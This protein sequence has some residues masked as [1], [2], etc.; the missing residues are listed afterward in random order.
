MKLGKK[1]I[2]SLAI[3]L[4]LVS[5]TVTTLLQTGTAKSQ[6]ASIPT[7]KT[8]AGISSAM[9]IDNHLFEKASIED[10]EVAQVTATF[11]EGTDLSESMEVRD[12]LEIKKQAVPPSPWETR[13]IAN[14]EGT[15]NVRDSA[16][17]TGAIVG[18]MSKGNVGTILESTGTWYKIQSGNVTGYVLGSF[19]LTGK[20]A[21][22]Y[23]NAIGITYAVASADGLRV[24][25]APDANA[26]IATTVNANAQLKVNTAVTAIEG[27]TAVLYNG[28]TGYISSSFVTITEILSTAIT[29]DEYN[30][31]LKAAEE[32]RKAAEAA[33]AA[34]AAKAKA[35]AVSSVNKGAVSASVDDETLL[36]ALIYCEAGNQSYQGKLAVGAVVMNRVRSGSYPN[37]ISAVIYQGG[38]FTPAFT[39]RLATALSRGVSSDCR[40]A[41]QEAIAGT[42]NVS[43]AMYFKRT[44]SGHSG[45][46]IGDHVFY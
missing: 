12:L 11:D 20:Q 28:K 37:S 31:I 45:I 29:M 30:A 15:L 43:G 1:A 32:A 23:A 38:Q 39:G 16:S 2:E 42:D 9:E 18:K 5:M 8:T 24:R 17:E 3:V 6:T 10:M 21:E 40:Q 4:L 7:Q 35:K 36:A 27:W 13:V 26:S 33:K 44:S 25:T 34:A 22:E 19:C 14:V 46:A 41:A